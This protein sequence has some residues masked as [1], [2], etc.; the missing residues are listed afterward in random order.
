MIFSKLSRA[1]SRSSRAR[2]VINGCHNG[3]LMMVDGGILRAS[4]DRKYVDG[5]DS[6]MGVLRSYLS[7]VAARKEPYLSDLNYVLACPKIR[8]FFSDEAPKKKNYENYYPK[9]K[10][11][12]PKANEQKSNSKD[13]LPSPVLSGGCLWFILAF[14]LVVV[15][16]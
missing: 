1:S 12:I 13:C 2:N 7:F 9:E 11:E 8:R 3:R 5:V 10:K 6:K 14:T 16:Q 15:M 4:S